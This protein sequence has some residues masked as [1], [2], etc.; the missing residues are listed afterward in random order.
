MTSAASRPRRE[1]LSEA[2]THRLS[3]LLR[4]L[5]VLEAEGVETISS[6]GLAQR[7]GVNAAQIRKDLA[8]LGEFGVRG[9][10]YGVADLRARL[11]AILGLDRVRVV[12]IVGAGHLGQALADSRNFNG[13]SFRVDAL[14]DV[15]GRKVGGKSRTGVPILHTGTLRETVARL[16]A[17]I[18]VLAVPAEDAEGSA[19]ALAEAGVRGIL[20]FAPATVGP[21]AGATVKNVDLTLSLETLAIQLTPAGG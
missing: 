7:L 12:V 11:G 2:A 10:G 3:L 15:D 6:P 5:G 14:F 16:G 8:H 21:F 17:E 18:G 20:N 9:V 1:G 4:S 13:E 19:R